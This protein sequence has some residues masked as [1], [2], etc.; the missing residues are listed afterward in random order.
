[1][2]FLYKAKNNKGEVVTGTVKAPSQYD[3]EKILVNH[4]LVTLEIIPEKKEQFSIK[5]GSRITSKDKAVFARQLS[6]MVSA[7]LPLAKAITVL[8]TQARTERLKNIYL[9]VYREV[10]EGSSFSS[11]LSKHPEMFDHIF[12]SVINSGET[13]GKLDVVLNQLAKQLEN[14]NNFTSRVKG[15]LYYPAFILLALISV[16]IYMVVAV[17]PKLKTMFDQSKTELPFA[18]KFLLAMSDFVI[19][20]WWLALIILFA[21]GSIFWFWIASESGKRAISYAQIKVPGVK[22]MTEGIYVS[23]FTRTLE[24]LV[25]AGVPLLDS[26]RT[27]SSMMQNEIYEESIL[28]IIDRVEK[29]VPLSTEL[30]K[31]PVFPPLVGQMAAVGEETGQLDQVLGKVADYYEEEVSNRVK[32]LS[33]LIEPVVLVII[34]L[35]VAF[36]VFAILVPIY[37]LTKIS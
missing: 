26:L 20:D 12:V 1:M 17:I 31:S 16:S 27:S 28:S 4:G 10:E 25:G 19:H 13:T 11:A 6:T 29:G 32:T 2:R 33:T 21:L 9:S 30:M 37:N 18:T 22:G 34:G 5:I 23:R 15:I 8:S 14:D 7:G 36:L 3:A 35:G 24:M